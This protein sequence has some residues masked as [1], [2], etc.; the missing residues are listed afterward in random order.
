MGIGTSGRDLYGDGAVGRE[1][2]DL[3]GDCNTL[4]LRFACCSILHERER[5]VTEGE[6]GERIDSER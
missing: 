5:A 2:G 4:L 6:C 3:Q 1:T